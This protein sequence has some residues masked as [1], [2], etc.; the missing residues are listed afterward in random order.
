MGYDHAH[1]ATMKRVLVLALVVVGVFAAY[2]DEVPVPFSG[3]LYLLSWYSINHD[4]G[5]GHVHRQRVP[6]LRPG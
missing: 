5:L 1:E 2:A 4:G 6:R 3:A